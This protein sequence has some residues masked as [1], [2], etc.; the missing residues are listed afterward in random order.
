MSE[1]IAFFE[2]NGKG[3]PP[4]GD[5][6]MENGEWK[7]EKNG[8]KGPQISQIFTD[9]NLCRHWRNLQRHVWHNLRPLLWTLI[10][11]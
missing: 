1:S 8:K 3:M 6:K 9:F 2:L 10:Q 11:S 4:A 5:L 7:I